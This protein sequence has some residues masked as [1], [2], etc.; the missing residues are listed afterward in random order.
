[1]LN[2]APAA[3]LPAHL[4]ALVDVLVPNEHEL[5]LLGSADSLIAAG[6]GAVVTTLGGAGV[7]VVTHDQEWHVATVRRRAHRHDRRRRRLLR[8]PRRPPRGR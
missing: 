2:P 8:C 7:R 1:M 6:V 4:Y 3:I 5:E